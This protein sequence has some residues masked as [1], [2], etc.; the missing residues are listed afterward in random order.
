VENEFE[1]V[2]VAEIDR[3]IATYD[4][5]LVCCHFRILDNMEVDLLFEAADYF[6]TIAIKNTRRVNRQDIQNLKGLQDFPLNPC[7]RVLSCRKTGKFIIIMLL[8]PFT[9]PIFC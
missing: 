9:R 7:D 4:L 3:R 1:S 8:L 5:P 6:V 2:I